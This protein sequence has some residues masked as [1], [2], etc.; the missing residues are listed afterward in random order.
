[1]TWWALLYSLSMLARYQ[2]E[3]WIDMLDVNRSPVAVTLES[4]LEDGVLAV[5]RLVMSALQ[6]HPYVE[7]WGSGD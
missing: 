1:M 2:P 3:K 6:G 7:S 4:I 5:P